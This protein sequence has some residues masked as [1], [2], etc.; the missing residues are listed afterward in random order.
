MQVKDLLQ[1]L[2]DL[3]LRGHGTK[4][5][6]FQTDGKSIPFQGFHSESVEGDKIIIK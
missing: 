6:L 2:Y 1:L 3:T 4:E 5:I